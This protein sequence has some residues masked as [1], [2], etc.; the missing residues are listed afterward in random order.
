MREL[1]EGEDLGGRGI[2]VCVNGYILHGYPKKMTRKFFNKSKAKAVSHTE[3]EERKDSLYL[4]YI[5]G[6]SEG[7]D[8]G[9][10]NMKIRTV[11][12]TTL[13]LR[14]CLTELKTPADP[15][16]T[17]GVV[18][19]IAC[20]CGRVYVGETG[21]MLKQRISKHKRVVKNA[22]SNNRLRVHVARTKHEINGMKQK[23][24]AG[25]NSG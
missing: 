9:V 3:K 19:R 7:V 20:S 15:I 4:P 24:Y 21:R 8:R 14:H 23:L 6:L 1:K 12:K 16:N 18:Y 5:R 25:K 22:D 11:C 2:P 17:K 10:K 13:T